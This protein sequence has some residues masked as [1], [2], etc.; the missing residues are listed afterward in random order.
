MTYNELQNIYEMLGY[1]EQAAGFTYFQ[2]PVAW[3][4]AFQSIINSSPKLME[5]FGGTNVAEI[6]NIAQAYASVGKNIYATAESGL[7]SAPVI[8]SVFTSPDSE[9]AVAGAEALGT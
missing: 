6:T 4:E 7:K 2:N 8:E 1:L 5:Y 3:Q 9:E